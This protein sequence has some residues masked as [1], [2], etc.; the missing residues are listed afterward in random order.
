MCLSL[1]CL[2]LLRSNYVHAYCYATQWTTYGPVYS[3][4]GVA[5]GTTIEACQQL[6]C[7]YYPGIP[8]C[9]QPAP[10]PCQDIVENHALRVLDAHPNRK[11]LGLHLNAMAVQHGE[12]V[13]CAVTQGHHHM[14]SGHSMRFTTGQ[15]GDAQAPYLALLERV[16]G[17]DVVGG[18]G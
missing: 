12:G 1:L 5:Q 17:L 3:S 7:Q 8:E 13:A 14:V 9:G 2:T 6:A 16:G 15:V 18:D 4:L 11:R 10:P